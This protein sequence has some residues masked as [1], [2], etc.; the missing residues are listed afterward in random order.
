[1]MLKGKRLFISKPFADLNLL[2]DWCLKNDVELVATSF[3]SFEPLSFQ[4]NQPFD[5]IFFGSSRAVSFFLTKNTIP[6]DVQIAVAGIATKEA[7]ETKGYT[8]NFCPKNS[9]QVHQSAMDFAS[10]VGSRTVLFPISTISKKS[11]TQHLT[12]EQCIP[13]EVYKTIITNGAIPP[14]DWYFFT[15]PSNVE[16]FLQLNNFPEHSKVIAFGQSTQEEL[17]TSTN[18]MIF[19]LKEA[20]E[21]AV[22]HYLSSI[23]A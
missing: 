4:I 20:S 19:A 9:G 1:M 3:I 5:V 13:V 14:A 2:P 6:K 15:S 8:A 18:R 21:E 16:G 22:I 10:W 12:Q 11:Y 17:Q 23:I 7:L